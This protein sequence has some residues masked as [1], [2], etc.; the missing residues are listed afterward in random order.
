MTELSRP[1]SSNP[2]GKATAEAKT[3]LPEED[4]DALA[5][6]ALIAGQTVSEYMR[7]LILEHLHG[8][9]WKVRV[10]QSRFNGRAGISPIQDGGEG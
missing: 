5:A 3:H 4:R 2:N 8:Q 7:D 10:A 1:T 6:L 9:L